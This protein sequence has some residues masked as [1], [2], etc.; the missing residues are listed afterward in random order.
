MKT[1]L[2]LGILTSTALVAPAAPSDWST[3]VST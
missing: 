1:T 3:T 2:L